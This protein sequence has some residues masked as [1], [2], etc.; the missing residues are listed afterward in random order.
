VQ[1]SVVKNIDFLIHID[2]ETHT[3]YSLV[4]THKPTSLYSF[5][6]LRMNIVGL[7]ILS[8]IVLIPT[9]FVLTSKVTIRILA[10]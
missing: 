4:D 6:L 3:L 8:M 9:D 5:N 2:T 7:R 10:I 1:T